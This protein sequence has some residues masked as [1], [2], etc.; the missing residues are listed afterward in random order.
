MYH[1]NTVYDILV[2]LS[3]YHQQCD[4]QC[5]YRYSLGFVITPKM[6]RAAIALFNASS[7]PIGKKQYQKKNHGKQLK[8]IHLV[9]DQIPHFYNFKVDYLYYFKKLFTY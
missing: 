5:Y 6:K 8:C 1:T 4:D 3:T 2:F 7:E 9:V